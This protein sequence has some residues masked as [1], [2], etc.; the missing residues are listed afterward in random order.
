MNEALAAKPDRPLAALDSD[1][2]GKLGAQEIAALNVRLAEYAVKKSAAP[3][4]A[5]NRAPKTPAIDCA[6]G[7]GT[8]TVTWQRPSE[9]VDDTPL[10]D[11]AGFVI[12]YGTSPQSL[13]CRAAVKDAA[14][15]KYVVERLGV[16]T[17]YFSVVAVNRDGVESPASDL[18]S[19]TIDK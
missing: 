4:K 9:N 11:L 14:A 2:D 13:P 6:A 12:R 19:K 3:K 7:T 18:A 16:G 10:K 15:T 8:A 5:G 1:G 17:W